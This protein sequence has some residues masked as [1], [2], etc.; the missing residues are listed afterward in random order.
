MDK[1]YPPSEERPGAPVTDPDARPVHLTPQTPN[2]TPV[3]V[4]RNFSITGFRTPATHIVDILIEGTIRRFHLLEPTERQRL[5][6]LGK[7]NLPPPNVPNDA[8][9]V[10]ALIWT[11]EVLA[12]TIVDEH[13]NAIMTPDEAL[14]FMRVYSRAA[15]KGDSRVK[16]VIEK[17]ISFMG[18]TDPVEEPDP[19]PLD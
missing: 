4:D 8:R 18:L 11:G 10:A 3:A 13:S 2:R 7:L 19:G 6:L 12:V 5:E 1:P 15:G 14:Q 17:A 9:S 16:P